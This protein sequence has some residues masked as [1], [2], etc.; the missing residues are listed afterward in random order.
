MRERCLVCHTEQELFEP[1]S[2][3]ET[4]PFCSSCGA[5]TERVAVLRT[6]LVSKSPHA[7]ALGRLGGTK[8]GPARA[9]AFRAERR[10]EI[11]RRAAHA[12]SGRA[13]R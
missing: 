2:A 7:V 3:D 9:A 1:C 11:A 5:A 6:G 8:G 4:G 10:R 12:R 13:K